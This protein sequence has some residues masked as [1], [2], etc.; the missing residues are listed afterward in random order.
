M[1][2][3]VEMKLV[4]HF[5]IFCLSLVYSLTTRNTSW[6]VGNGK[7]FVTLILLIQQNYATCTTTTMMNMNVKK[8]I[9]HIHTMKKF[10]LYSVCISHLQPKLGVHRW[11]LLGA[12][13]YLWPF[14]MHKGWKLFIWI[15]LE[16]NLESTSNF[17]N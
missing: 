15:T 9:T 13:T 11:H 12:I 14:T 17:Y 1:L 3:T 2:C 5:E 16:T 7:S 10:A 4:Y 8:F 6:Y